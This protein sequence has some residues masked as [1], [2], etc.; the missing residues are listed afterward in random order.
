MRST[1]NSDSLVR[2]RVASEIVDGGLRHSVTRNEDLAQA[3]CLARFRIGFQVIREHNFA[4]AHQIAC[5][6]HL[7]ADAPTADA[8]TVRRRQ[9]T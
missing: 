6:D 8:P 5:L 3:S 1:P 2:H 7:T 4:G 9:T